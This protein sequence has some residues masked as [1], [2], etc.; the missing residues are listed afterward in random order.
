MMP[1]RELKAL[2]KLLDDDQ[3]YDSV[4]RR[5]IE[6]GQNAIPYLQGVIRDNDPHRKTRARLILREIHYSVFESEWISMLRRFQ[7]RDLHLE[8]TAWFIARIGYPALDAEHYSR[9]IDE[10]AALVDKRIRLTDR[11]MA[12]LR[13]MVGVLAN[14]EG[15]TGN[16][17]NY[18]E[19]DNSFL[20]RVI[21]R[22]KGIPITLSVLYLL[23]G[24]RLNIPLKGVGIPAHFMVKYVGPKHEYDEEIYVDPFHQ[25]RFLGRL[26]VERFC[27]RAG[28]GF[29]ENYLMPL[30]NAEI[31]ERMLRNLVFVYTRTGNQ[32]QL[33]RL[34][35]ILDL[36]AEHYT[37]LEEG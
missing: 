17:E 32:E 15:F 28:L 23:V 25:G 31:V 3:V 26:A 1:S 24:E 33:H 37:Q 22:K 18:Y 4:R 16:A 13:R 8:D 27:L 20:N 10:L 6:H 14:R 35:T 2:I 34:Q 29:N 9:K 36:Y 30:E 7:G 19:A 21:D 12:K 5:L 11:P